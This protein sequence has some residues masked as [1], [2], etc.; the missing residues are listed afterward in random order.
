MKLQGSA[1]NL[2]AVLEQSDRIDWNSG[3]ESYGKYNR[4]MTLLA[5]KYGCTLEQ[6]TAVFVST[7]PNNDYKNN[8]RSTVSILDGW[9]N[10]RPD[11]KIRISTYTHCKTRALEYL[12]GK[13]FLSATKGPKI[14]AFFQNIVDPTNRQPV[15]VDGHMVGAWSGKRLLMKEVAHSSFKYE[16]VAEDVRKVARFVDL[17]PCQVQGIL[18][19]TWKRINSA[20]YN[21][22]LNL[23]GDHWGLDIDPT[24]IRPFN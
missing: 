8:L 14:T 13:D 2:C 23:F 7:S 11:E 20:V 12:R 9:A 15:T 19:F 5:K 21:G 3:C 17:V 16:E 22:N 18:W 10:K 4:L 1:D 6:A 24:T